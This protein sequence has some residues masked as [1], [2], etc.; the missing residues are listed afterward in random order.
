ME[1]RLKSAA[2]TR[3]WVF[4]DAL[5]LLPF[6][7]QQIVFVS[8]RFFYDPSQVCSG[9]LGRFFGIGAGSTWK[10]DVQKPH[11]VWTSLEVFTSPSF[12]CSGVGEVPPVKL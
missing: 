12:S 9:V 2:M 3:V 4:A 5:P 11:V 8:L 10:V 7:P 1:V 6:I